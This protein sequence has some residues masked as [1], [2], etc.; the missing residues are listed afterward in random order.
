[1]WWTV[2]EY[3]CH[4]W[5]GICCMCRIQNPV[6]PL[7]MNCLRV[8]N[9]GCYYLMQE[10]VNLMDHVSAHPGLVGFVLLNC[11]LLCSVLFFSP[12]FIYPSYYLSFYL[13]LLITHLVSFK[14]FFSLN[15]GGHRE[16]V[17]SNSLYMLYILSKG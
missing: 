17:N 3:L 15:C 12:F 10:L 1:M 6:I 2:T 7:F 11:S 14:L 16:P 13:W 4:K 9:D 8:C 5:Q